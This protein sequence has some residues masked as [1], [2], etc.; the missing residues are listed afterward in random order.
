MSRVF[1]EPGIDVA[2]HE[3]AAH[4]HN[5]CRARGIAGSAIDFL[6]CAVARRERHVIQLTA[7]LSG[8][9]ECWGLGCLRSREAKI[10]GT[11]VARADMN[12]GMFI[13]TLTRWGT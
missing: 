4:M 3:E 12:Q 11:S 6:I 2:D 7:T 1:D 8:T 5:L 9:G 10:G 13:A